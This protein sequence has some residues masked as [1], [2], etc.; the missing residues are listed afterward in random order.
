ML[1][2]TCVTLLLSHT[3]THTI[4]LLQEDIAKLL[5][6]ESSALPAGQQT[7]LT[8]YGSRMKAGTRNIYYLF[9]PTPHHRTQPPQPA[10]L[11]LAATPGVTAGPR[12][13]PLSHRHQE[14]TPPTGFH[15][16]RPTPPHTH[17]HSPTPPPPPPPPPPHTHR[18]MP[19]T[20]THGRAV[21]EVSRYHCHN[22]P[23]EQ[24]TVCH[25]APLLHDR[26]STC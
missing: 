6:Y 22:K 10:P 16:R 11:P 4:P 13:L 14:K 18:H 5:R 21:P 17:T 2:F 24:E 8:E 12:Q 1:C 7:N 15:N 20:Q 9:P 25:R 3:H 19:P 23:R 26:K